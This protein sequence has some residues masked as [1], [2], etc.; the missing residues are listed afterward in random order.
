[1]QARLPN[2]SLRA[3]AALALCVPLALGVSSVPARS[4]VQ[5]AR[6][7]SGAAFARIK[8]VVVNGV[9]KT[10]G[11]TIKEVKVVREHDSPPRNPLVDAGEPGMD[12]FPKDEV[13]MGLG[14]NATIVFVLDPE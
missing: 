2:L 1:M 9:E 7:S 12:L 4:R 11:I 8:N 13:V 6:R 14:T 10:E 3:A 5:P